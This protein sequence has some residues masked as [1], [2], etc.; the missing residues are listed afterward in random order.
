[1]EFTR[2]EMV[3]RMRIQASLA[4]KM[5]IALLVLNAGGAVMHERLSFQVGCVAGLLAFA[6]AFMSQHFFVLACQHEMTGEHGRE[7]QCVIAGNACYVP[8]VLLALA[9]IVAF[10]IGALS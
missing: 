2:A 5:M 1:M 7:R 3:E 10:A 9:G 4:E 8:G 6:A